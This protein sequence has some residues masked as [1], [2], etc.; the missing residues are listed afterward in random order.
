V[1]SFLTG[2]KDDS[3]EK[4]AGGLAAPTVVVPFLVEPESGVAA[5]TPQE[6]AAAAAAAGF[7][8][9]AK[10]VGNTIFELLL[11]A[12]RHEQRTGSPIFAPEMATAVFALFRFHIL[13]EGNPDPHTWRPTLMWDGYSVNHTAFGLQCINSERSS[14]DDRTDR[15][16]DND[17]WDLLRRVYEYFL[18]SLTC[19]G[20][21]EGKPYMDAVG[22]Y[23]Q[24]N[25]PLLTR[26]IGLF[27]SFDTRERDMV[28]KIL[29]QIYGN[30][31]KVRAFIREQ[32][33]VLI[34]TAV[35]ETHHFEGIPDLLQLLVSVVN[36]YA[37]PLKQE[38][39]EYLMGVLMPLYTAPPLS[40]FHQLLSSCVMQVFLTVLVFPI[41]V[42]LT[43]LMFPTEIVLT[44]GFLLKPFL[45]F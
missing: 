30:F 36:G 23:L 6:I 40:E 44:V 34:L 26:I 14:D 9:R 29:F 25:K 35:Y 7:A 12:K 11:A 43:V 21:E 20:Q 16:H 33:K 24:A 37:R 27:Q 15:F 22:K 28:K 38:H 17:H 13:G 18:A 4:K 19:A 8:E 5:Q 32:I 3:E 1:R 39:K 2:P 41:E 10:Q 42:V 45:L 31:T